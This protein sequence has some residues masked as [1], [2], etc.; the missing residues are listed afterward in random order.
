MVD[1]IIYELWYRDTYSVR[2]RSLAFEKNTYLVLLLLPI[3]FLLVVFLLLVL[4]YNTLVETT[5]ICQV[6]KT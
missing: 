5:P 6:V 2:T 3:Y 4:H 1:D